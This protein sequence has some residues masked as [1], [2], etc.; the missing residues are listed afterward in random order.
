VVRVLAAVIQRQA[1]QERQRKDKTVDRVLA[2]IQITLVA[3][4]VVLVRLVSMVSYQQ[5]A[6]QAV[7]DWH[8]QLL[9]RQLHEA[10]VVVVRLVESQQV[11]QWF[12]AAQAAQAAAAQAAEQVQKTV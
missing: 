10:A 1:V 6:A 8:Q 4:A 2:Q 9:D 3:A 11:Q 5:A 7:Q 12:Q